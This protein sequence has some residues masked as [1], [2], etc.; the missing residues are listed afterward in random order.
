[1]LV[2][3]AVIRK[4]DLVL[5]NDIICK[6]LTCRRVKQGNGKHGFPKIEL[7]YTTVETIE[8]GIYVASCVSD[9]EKISD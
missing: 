5:I 9:I 1:M 7:T 6:V 8:K 3:I 4:N 2:H